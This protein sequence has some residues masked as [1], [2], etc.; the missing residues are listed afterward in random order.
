MSP[1]RGVDDLVA[2]QVATET[3]G[4]PLAIVE[5]AEAL[6]AHRLATE[7]ATPEP[8]PVGGRLQA[9][10]L[11][12]IDLLPA[13]TRTLLLVKAADSSGEPGIVAAAAAALGVGPTHRR[14]R[15]P[16]ASSAHCPTSS[17]GIR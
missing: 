3:D 7:A 4:L 5:L 17:S 9:H 12:S 6:S 16:R 13:A 1:E 8:L 2:R 10:F 15:S 11:R 14:R